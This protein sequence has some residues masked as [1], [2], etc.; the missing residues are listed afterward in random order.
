MV[1]Y[2]N[3]TGTIILLSFFF[4]AVKW[5]FDYSVHRVARMRITGDS[6]EIHDLCI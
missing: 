1:K 5:S 6:K 3:Q 2:L 4:I